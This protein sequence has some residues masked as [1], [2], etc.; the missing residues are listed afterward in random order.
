M[1]SCLCEIDIEP[2]V[3]KLLFAGRSQKGLSVLGCAE[4]QVK[5]VSIN[6]TMV[7]KIGFGF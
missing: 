5:C 1:V 6:I 4:I 3:Q 2:L 7:M